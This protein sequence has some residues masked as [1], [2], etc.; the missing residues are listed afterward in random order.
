M[1]LECMGYNKLDGESK[2]NTKGPEN[3][4]TLI[5]AF[6]NFDMFDFEGWTT[7]DTM[8]FD[9]VY[10]QMWDILLKYVHVHRCTKLLHKCY[11]QF[12]YSAVLPDARCMLCDV[13]RCDVIYWIKRNCLIAVAGC[14][15][16]TQTADCAI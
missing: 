4:K 8:C 3:H 9:D 7:H 12:A 13:M 15:C 5:A 1:F 2:G 11:E 10:A 6:F 14:I 16:I